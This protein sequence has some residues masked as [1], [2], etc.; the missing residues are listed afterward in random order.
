[1]MGIKINGVFLLGNSVLSDVVCFRQPSG[2]F[3]YFISGENGALRL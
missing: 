1:M 3:F 2:I